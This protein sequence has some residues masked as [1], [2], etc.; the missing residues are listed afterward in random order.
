METKL[1][2]TCEAYPEQYDFYLDDRKIGYLRLRWGYFRAEYVPSGET[3]YEAY[4]K[5]DG[6]FDSDERDYY[7]KRAL[8]A[9]LLKDATFYTK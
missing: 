6:I 2:K 9:L 7:L 5:G 8:D 1:I 3:A 4:P